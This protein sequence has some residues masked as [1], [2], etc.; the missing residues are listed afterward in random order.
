MRP[1]TNGHPPAGRDDPPAG[2]APDPLAA[3]EEL[4]AAL[5]DAGVKAGRLVAA[6]KARQKEKKALTQA[7]S[8]LRALNLGGG[9]GP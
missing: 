7:W 6:L 8:S 3:A 5:V 9:G 4:R 1:E 2:D